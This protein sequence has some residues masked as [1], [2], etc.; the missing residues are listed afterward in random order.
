MNTRK[1]QTAYTVAK[2]V[3]SVSWLIIIAGII[4]GIILSSE[5]ENPEIGI[6]IALFSLLFGLVLVLNSQMVLIYIDTENNTRNIAKENQ[7]TNAMLSKVLGIPIMESD[8]DKDAIIDSN[9][10]VKPEVIKKK[11]VDIPEDFKKTVDDMKKD[12]GQNR[13]I[14]LKN[15]KTVIVLTKTQ[16]EYFS[17]DDNYLMLYNNFTRPN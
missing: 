12:L 3:E 6:P 1:Y 10:D 9:V 15:N 11:G 2:V 4:F 8:N 14:V 7:K 16:W 5:Y 13:A 17:N